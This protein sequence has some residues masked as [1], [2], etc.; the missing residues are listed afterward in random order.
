MHSPIERSRPLVE[1]LEERRL[2]SAVVTIEG[3]R[4]ADDIVISR[5]ATGRYDVSVNGVH[6]SYR[7]SRVRRM[8]VIAGRGDDHVTVSNDNRGVSVFRTIAGGDGNDTLTGGKGEDELVGQGGDDVLDGRQ[9]NDVEDG[10]AGDDSL[11][12]GVGDDSCDGGEGDDDVDG[13][14]GHDHVHGGGGVDRFHMGHDDATEFEDDH[15]GEDHV[16][17]DQAGHDVNDDNG[18]DTGGGGVDDGPGHH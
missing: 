7:A 12:G 14:D 10:G 4:R 15:S 17:D 5:S 6:T 3:T 8:V 9:G 2:L 16:F 18:G 11:V 13:G 1:S